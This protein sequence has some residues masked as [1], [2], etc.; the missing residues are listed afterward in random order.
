MFPHVIRDRFSSDNSL[1]IASA[2]PLSAA[3][4]LAQAT[5]VPAPLHPLLGDVARTLSP[6][7]RG[8]AVYTDD[9]APVEWLTD[10]S[11]LRYAAGNR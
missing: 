3:E 8:G 7:L 1:L 5:A 6:P 4:M 11:I 10:L 9:R 2:R